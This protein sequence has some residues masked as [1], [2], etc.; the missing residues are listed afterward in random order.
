MIKEI[1]ASERLEIEVDKQEYAEIVKELRAEEDWL[2]VQ[3]ELKAREG[4]FPD[5]YEVV[6]YDP[7]IG[8]MRWT[9]VVPDEIIGS[10]YGNQTRCSVA[11]AWR[12]SFFRVGEVRFACRLSLF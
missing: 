2:Y 5:E 1:L 9:D 3:L 7:G 11:N 6:S 8:R 12:L 4:R 10:M